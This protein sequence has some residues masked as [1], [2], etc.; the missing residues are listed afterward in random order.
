MSTSLNIN[1][2]IKESMGIMHEW[3]QVVLENVVTLRELRDTL[4]L[5]MKK[6]DNF[7]DLM[8]NAKASTTNLYGSMINEVD[9]YKALGEIQTKNNADQKEYN[10]WI[11]RGSKQIPEYANELKMINDNT[12]QLRSTMLANAKATMDASQKTLGY[13]QSSFSL[14]GAM[15]GLQTITKSFNNL[16]K[17]LSGEYS[18]LAWFQADVAWGMQ[19]IGDII[20]ANLPIFDGLNGLLSTLIGF[21]EWLP[22]PLQQALGTFLYFGAQVTGAASTIMNFIVAILGLAVMENMAGIFGPA[23]WLVGIYTKVVGAASIAVKGLAASHLALGYAIAAAFAGFI[24]GWAAASAL[25]R[26]FG[27]MGRVI[28]ILIGVVLAGAAAWFAYH[29]AMSGPIAPITAAIIIASIAAGIGMIMTGL[30]VIPH[31]ELGGYVTKGGV[32]VLH[33]AEV[34]TPAGEVG[35][36]RTVNYNTFHI[37]GTVREE[38]D[39]DLIAKKVVEI[40]KNE[41]E[42]RT[43]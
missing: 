43:Y 21:I 37:E 25:I 20:F 12:G 14:L 32:A 38:A 28:S 13:R 10:K 30:G 39:I 17:D 33:P 7:T 4:V 19:D 15:F 16:L 3:S 27:D 31:M 29:V 1:A 35:T 23:S 40:Q 42:S 11:A 18:D 5:P 8:N 22:A 36:G 9:A 41:Y 6:T 2:K 34:V 26:V 24:A